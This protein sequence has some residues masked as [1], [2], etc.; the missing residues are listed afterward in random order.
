MASIV[1]SSKFRHVF[2][3]AAKREDSY[4]SLR[5]STSAWDTNFVTANPKYLAVNWNASGGGAFSVIPLHMQGKLRSEFPLFTAHVGAVLDT[6]FCPFDDDIIASGAEDHQAMV[7]RVPR[8]LE[9]RE[10]DVTEPIAVLGGHGRKVGHVLWNPVAADVLAVSSSD[11]TVRIWDV[12]TKSMRVTLQGFKDTVLSIAWSADGRYLAAT[13]RDKQLRVF[14]GRTGELK[15]QGPSHLGVKG[16]RVVWLSPTRLAT[17]GFSR[18]SD[19]QLYLWDATNLA[20]PLSTRNIDMSAGML[21]PFYDPRTQILYLGG[22]GDGNIRYYEFADDTL[23]ELSAYLSVEPQRGLGIM[24]KRGVDVAHCEVMRF[25]K[26][27]S[28]SLIE[29][30]SF[31]VPRKAETFQSDIYPP[32]FA[33][34]A[35]MS[36]DE[37]FAGVEKQPLVVDMEAVFKNGPLVVGKAAGEI[38]API[39]PAEANVSASISAPAPAPAPVAA[40]IPAPAAELDSLRQENTRLQSALNQATEQLKS[41]ES[42]QQQAINELKSKVSSSESQANDLN[43]QL[44]TALAQTKDYR[45]QLEA[46]EAKVSD[47]LAQLSSVSA[48]SAEYQKKLVEAEA[49]FK[50]TEEGKLKAEDEVKRVK[51]ELKVAIDAANSLAV[52]AER[53]TEFL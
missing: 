51:D 15:Q 9:E 49:I 37:Y 46:Q 40:P 25:Y 8:D 22:K 27:A 53:A 43:A 45:S 17:T 12:Q 32:D 21:M 30:V 19:R 2:G 3:T 11:Y 48:Q 10:G 35:A 6:A 14:D 31:K 52:A 16:S 13:C 20:K 18:S 36:A 5:V 42:Q 39:K 41:L 7:W 34:V 44:T 47:I 23:Y 4:E 29:P 24:P 28:D 38:K 26:V 33:G 1:R 50:A